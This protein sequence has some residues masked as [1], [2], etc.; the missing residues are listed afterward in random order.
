MIKN[1][2]EGHD[3][4]IVTKVTIYNSIM[5]LYG[6]PLMSHRIS[7]DSQHSF[8]SPKEVQWSTYHAVLQGHS[9]KLWTSSSF[10]F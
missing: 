3:E 1:V 8:V 10:S 9:P 6:N 7:V 5:A 4:L 2:M